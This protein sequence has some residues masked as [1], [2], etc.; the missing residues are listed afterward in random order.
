MFGSKL[1]IRK[2]EDRIEKYEAVPVVTGIADDYY[3][4]IKSG[5]EADTVVFTQM[6]TT[7]VWM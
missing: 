1:K 3:V 6:M 4:E 7:E 2:F 5:V